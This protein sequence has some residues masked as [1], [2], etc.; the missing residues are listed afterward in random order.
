MK[1]SKCGHGRIASG[2]KPLLVILP[3]CTG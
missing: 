3:V 2:C 1:T